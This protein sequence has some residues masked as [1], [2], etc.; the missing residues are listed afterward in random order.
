MKFNLFASETFLKHYMSD[1]QDGNLGFRTNALPQTVLEN[2]RNLARKLNISLEQLVVMQQE[3]TANVR[4]VTVADKG[5]GALEKTTA[6]AAT[7]GLITDNPDVVL[8]AQGA[9]CPLLLFFEP[10][11]KVLGVAHSGW[12]GFKAGIISNILQKFVQEYGCDPAKIKVGITPSAEQCCYEVGPELIKVFSSFPQDLFIN[13][14]GKIFFDLKGAIQYQLLTLKVL[15]ENIESIAVCTICDD[16][17]FS[18]RREKENAGR[19]ALLAWM[20]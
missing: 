19:F 17:F 15:P 7:D 14:N 3:H 18:Y 5:K 11:R 2:R 12:K 16:N 10:N 13:K 20:E 1:K 4:R 6:L 8:M 9:D